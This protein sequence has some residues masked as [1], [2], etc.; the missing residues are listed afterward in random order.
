MEEDVTL[1]LVSLC[2]Y[3]CVLCS[4]IHL[5]FC[6]SFCYITPLSFNIY[7]PF[8]I[9]PIIH[10]SLNTIY[11]S[12]YPCDPYSFTHF[13]F[14]QSFCYITPSMIQYNIYS[15]FFTLRPSS[16]IYLFISHSSIC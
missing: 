4:F 7:T 9:H 11:S 8:V 15:F 2:K 12:L 3:P 14:C 13:H 10:P 1:K 5:H 6:Q 16:I